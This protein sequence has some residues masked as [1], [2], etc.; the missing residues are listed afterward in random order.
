MLPSFLTTTQGLDLG[1]L[2]LVQDFTVAA[3]TF[4]ARTSCKPVLFSQISLQS[5]CPLIAICTHSI[6][7]SRWHTPSGA[8][9]IYTSFIPQTG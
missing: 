9:Y 2:L 1:P 6:S 8:Q 5:Y 7:L 3:L 4:Y